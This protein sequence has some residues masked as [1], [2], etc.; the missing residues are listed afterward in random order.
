MTQ[1]Y[2]HPLNTAGESE[3]VDR[4]DYTNGIRVY[5]KG[6]PFPHKGMPTEPAV[7]ATNVVKKIIMMMKL[8]RI[9]YFNILA[10]EAFR[11]YVLRPEFMTPAASEL[12]SVLKCFFRQLG[13][14]EET[15]SHLAHVVEYD[16]AYRLRM[17]DLFSETTKEKL[18]RAPVREI[19]RLIEINKKRDYAVVTNK[20]RKFAKIAT[21]ALLIPPIRTAFKKAIL[22]S[23]YEKLCLDEGD[24]YWIKKR[25]DYKWN[26]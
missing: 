16:N 20:F 21:I 4:V 15:A 3:V 2:K 1:I 18:C 17:Q 5:F 13:L 23:D 26:A 14:P 6:H 12:M 24:R 22:N 7:A 11:P 10:R 9:T 8:P 19:W 25:L